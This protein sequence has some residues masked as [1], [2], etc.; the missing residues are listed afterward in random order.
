MLLP[1]IQYGTWFS[2]RPFPFVER[3]DHAAWVSV[4]PS[5]DRRVAFFPQSYL[6]LRLLK[7]VGWSSSVGA[8]IIGIAKS[9]WID[10]FDFGWTGFEGYSSGVAI[11]TAVDYDRRQGEVVIVS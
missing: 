10:H 1:T 9:I 4:V 5:I 3:N 6:F 7:G 2:P 11:D 8:S